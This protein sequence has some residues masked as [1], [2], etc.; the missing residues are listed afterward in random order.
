MK[1]KTE[2]QGRQTKKTSAKRFIKTIS[3][4]V[5]EINRRQEWRLE[6]PLKTRIEGQLANGQKF[7]ENTVID[8]ISSGGSYF[9][10]NAGITVGSK[11]NMIVDLPKKLGEGQPLK[12]RIG[13]IAVRLEKS[14]KKGKRQGVAVKFSDD[15]EIFPVTK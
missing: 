1:K 2:S 12:L 14:T 9:C 6:L 10:L 3:P 13:G 7:Q 8:N 15:F 4:T 5:V 11:L